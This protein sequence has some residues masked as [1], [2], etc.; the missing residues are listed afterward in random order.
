MV[1]GP[2][3]VH[4]GRARHEPEVQV[5]SAPQR[6]HRAAE[7]ERAARDQ[8]TIGTLELSTP[9][10]QGTRKHP[11]RTLVSLT[12][13]RTPA[14]DRRCGGRQLEPF[15]V[16]RAYFSLRLGRGLGTDRGSLV[17]R[18]APANPLPRPSGAGRVGADAHS[19]AVISAGREASYAKTEIFRDNCWWQIA[20][21]WGGRI[22]TN[23]RGWEC[24]TM[25]WRIG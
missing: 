21:N 13:V 24:N 1:C 12:Q 4:R 9:A 15:S 2:T 7:T 25:L 18:A 10:P 20:L 17:P 16:P 22:V 3:A 5:G 19:T 11:D 6:R 14:A 8:T 23:G